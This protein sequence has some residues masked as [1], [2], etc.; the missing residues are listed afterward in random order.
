MKTNKLMILFLLLPFLCLADDTA[1]LQAQFNNKV[2][3]V[4]LLNHVYHV[5]SQLNLNCPNVN[6]NGSSIVTSA[7]SGQI[8]SGNVSSVLQNGT[9]KGNW[10][11]FQNPSNQLSGVVATGNNMSIINVHITGVSGT[12]VFASGNNFL[13]N[14][15]VVDSTGYLCLYYDGEAN[16]SGVKIINCRFDRS[17]ILASAIVE[18]AVCIRG[19]ADSQ[20]SFL[21]KKVVFSGNIVKMPLNP[22]DWDASGIELRHAVNAQITSNYFYGGS[23]SDSNVD[24][25]SL[26]IRF[27]KCLDFQLEAVELMDIRKGSL[28]RNSING[29]SSGKF[30][31]NQEQHGL[32][33]EGFTE[34]SHALSISQDTIVNT[35]ASC[36]NTNNNM[37]SGLTFTNVKYSMTTP[38]SSVFD[39]QGAFDVNIVNGVFD[40]GKSANECVMLDTSIGD[41]NITGS[42][43]NN[44]RLGAVYIYSVSGTAVNNI[45]LNNVSQTGTP[46]GLNYYG[47]PIIGNNNSVN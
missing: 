3:V 14:H 10:N 13:M 21:V 46:L 39:L 27:N 11:V 23:M 31:S 43:I 2:P 38:G 5:S 26:N 36:I 42:M 12:G 29:N 32:M 9:L 47:N 24:V 35:L 40:G 20:K 4:L 45:F 25:Q 15:V 7:T 37:V 6:L 17:M 28:Y 41:I 22:D 33:I 44:F 8:V 1:T 30:V 18:G 34:G 19:T 16:T